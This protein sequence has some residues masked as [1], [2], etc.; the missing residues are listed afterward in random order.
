M[1][2]TDFLDALEKKI[3]GIHTPA[4]LQSFEAST[5]SVLNKLMS[6]VG[7]QVDKLKPLMTPPTDL[8]SLVS[9]AKSV[10]DTFAQ[11][12]QTLLIKVTLY[13][14]RIARIEAKLAAKASEL[15]QGK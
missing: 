15:S 13:T 14:E 6:D 12:Y 2:D 7:A 4:A 1:A 10:S 5:M 8:P 9:W 11:P 3:D